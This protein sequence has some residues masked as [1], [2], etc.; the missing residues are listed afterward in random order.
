MLSVSN[1]LGNSSAQTKQPLLVYSL[2]LIKCKINNDF[3]VVYD[4]NYMYM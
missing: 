1:P 4:I 2:V 3:Y